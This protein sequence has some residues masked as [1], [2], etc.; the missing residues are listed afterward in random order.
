MITVAGM[1]C[2]FIVKL[3]LS[4]HQYHQY[5][6]DDIIIITISHLFFSYISNDYQLSSSSSLL[7][8]DVI[9]TVTSLSSS[10][11]YHQYCHDDTIIIP[12]PYDYHHHHN[13]VMVLYLS[14]SSSSSTRVILFVTLRCYVSMSSIIMVTSLSPWHQYHYGDVINSSPSYLLMILYRLWS[15]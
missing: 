8:I 14:F 7:N 1:M 2:V 15:S 12:W 6:Y 11:W 4:L 10:G 3:V 5:H 9:I 13:D